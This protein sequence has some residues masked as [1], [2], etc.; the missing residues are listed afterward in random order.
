MLGNVYGNKKYL[1][2]VYMLLVAGKDGSEHKDIK[3]YQC[4]NIG[5]YVSIFPD[6]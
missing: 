6:K 1:T 2:D 3:L 4:H 5:Q